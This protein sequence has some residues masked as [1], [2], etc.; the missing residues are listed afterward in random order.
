MNLSTKIGIFITGFYCLHYCFTTVH[1]DDVRYAKF[2][3]DSYGKN[4]TQYA[5]ERGIDEFQENFQKYKTDFQKNYENNF[6]NDYR[7]TKFLYNLEFVQRQNSY[8]ERR[9][10]PFRLRINQFADQVCFSVHVL[11][12]VWT[13]PFCLF[14]SLVL[15]S[16]CLLF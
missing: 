11:C 8:Y 14:F 5:R 4:L 1:C 7:A 12:R 13:R 6:E 10:I 9:K 3:A 15:F 16:F 2:I